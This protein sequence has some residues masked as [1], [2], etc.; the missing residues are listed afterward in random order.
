M[1][2]FIDDEPDYIEPFRDAFVLSGFEVQLINNVDSAWE[3]IA[4]N[5]EDVDAIILDIMMPPGRLLA[6]S[7]TKEGLRTGLRFIELMKSLD[8]TIPVICLT[9]AD[10]K[11][12]GHVDHGHCFFYEKKDADPWQLVDKM[13]DIKRRKKL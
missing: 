8:E 13:S 12:F 2:F 1:I 5:K 6:D 4:K 11:K 7:D 10:C 3:L 9:N